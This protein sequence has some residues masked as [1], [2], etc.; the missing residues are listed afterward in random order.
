MQK[1][2]L[3]IPV[4]LNNGELIVL[5]I[6]GASVR[7]R[8][9]DVE[10]ADSNGESRFQLVEG[11]E[12][13]Y[14]LT[15]TRGVPVNYQLQQNEDIVR[16]SKRHYN[17][18]TIKTGIFVGTLTATICDK[19][20]NK[21]GYIEIEI[22]SFKTDYRTDYRDMLHEITEFYTDLLMQQGAVVTQ[23]FEIDHEKSSETLYQKFSFVKSL[24]EN[25]SFINA[26]HKVIANP[27]NRWESTE[28]NNNISNTKKFTK[29]SL[30]QI[31]TSHD[32]IPLSERSK[33]AFS[34]PS[35]ISSLPRTLSVRQKR[36]TVDNHENQFVKY[37]L[38]SFYTFC[39]TVSQL[40]CANETLKKEAGVTM[41]HIRSILDNTFFRGISKPVHL[42]L[43]SPV[44][45]RKEGYREVL[46][47]WL[48]FDLAAKLSWRGGNDIYQ[49]GKRNVAVLYE[50]W[51]F[52]KLLSIIS[53]TFNVPLSNT[54]HLV[55]TDADG[56]NLE[57]K[58]GRM[59]AL[60]GHCA[61]GNRRMNL[62]LYYNRTFMHTNDIASSGSWTRTMR[63]DYTLSI[64]TGSDDSPV[65]E[66]EAE[67][68]EKIVH[69]HFDAKYRIESIPVIEQMDD[70]ELTAEKNESELHIYKRGDLLKM[71]A[72]K[73]AIRRTSGAYIIYPGN[74]HAK[75]IRGYHE[76][77]PGLGAFCLSPSSSIDDTKEIQ[78]FLMEI[79][80]HLMNRASER[81]RVAFHQHEIYLGEGNG[82]RTP[83]NAHLPELLDDKQLVP[84]ETYVLVGYYK[85]ERQLNWILRE[86]KYNF[87]AGFRSG[88]LHMESKIVSAR[89]VI[90]RHGNEDARLFK[91]PKAG[92][93]VV[94][95]S[96]L[97]AKNYPRDNEEE[98]KKKEQN[99]YLV[100]DLEQ[101][102]PEFLQYKWNS[103]KVKQR[104]GRQSAHP[105]WMT[106]TEL[107]LLHE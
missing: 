87:R 83:L 50:Y 86:R 94:T 30:R 75:K 65:G 106:L 49:A 16:H 20:G 76:I 95:R 101:P 53:E 14:E 39:Q 34:L 45:Q 60:R 51:V 48:M 52:F 21:M 24:V 69:I 70:T 64:W 2:S 66:S 33:R 17:S 7:S 5:H 72:Y 79:R 62:C 78:K 44:L 73:D 71:H 43:N 13:E 32:R 55:T 6:L 27:V 46:Q 54:S 47:A 98:E 97:L 57:L 105:D 26:V 107:M 40:K 85:D 74:V 25:D 23:R 61:A 58:Q 89:Y 19:F 100:Y 41:S 31:A 35:N 82:E 104:N 59:T 4:T 81:E 1:E 96:G 18:G 42:N 91:L 103:A 67:R 84:D 63:P 92:P 88:T 38:T 3:E 99:V 77:I 9:Y 12:Y 90:L 37:V 28:I 10:D 29:E 102:E 11:S 80:E 93:I 68:N 22:Q 8:L 36:E 15:D 56:I